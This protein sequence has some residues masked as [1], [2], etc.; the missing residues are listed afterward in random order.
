MKQDLIINRLYSVFCRLSSA[1]LYICRESSTNQ[2]FYAKQTQFP[3]KSND[4]SFFYTKEYENKHNWTIG[5]NKPNSNPIQTQSNP[6]KAQKMPI[7]TQYK[8]KQTQSPRPK[9]LPI[10]LGGGKLRTRLWEILCEK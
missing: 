6:I 10:R 3:K 7:Q 5:Q 9:T 8:P 4:V 1:F 2:P